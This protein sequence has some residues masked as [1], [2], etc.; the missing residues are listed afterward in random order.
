[1]AV[2]YN[3]VNPTHGRQTETHH[4]HIM[5]YTDIF[6]AEEL[7]TTAHICVISHG[8]DVVSEGENI[9]H[10][11][12]NVEVL[13][14]AGKRISR[15]FNTLSVYSR[16]EENKILDYAWNSTSSLPL[17][18]VLKPFYLK[19]GILNECTMYD[20]VSKLI[21]KALY[22]T[23]H[24]DERLTVY[25]LYRFLEKAVSH[26]IK[27]LSSLSV[28]NLM[29]ADILDEQDKMKQLAIA[30]YPRLVNAIMGIDNARIC[31]RGL[32]PFQGAIEMKEPGQ[33]TSLPCLPNMFYSLI[34]EG[35]KVYHFVEC[36]E[37]GA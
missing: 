30:F 19:H 24:T 17:V 18:D 37:I 35:G 28:Y 22:W 1:M 13:I 29:Y 3:G 4:T 26:E 11:K 9:R 6:K 15:T 20:L 5:K 36:E 7:E 23:S 21:V 10:D 2:A 31:G 16:T 33:C 14:M 34:E 12:I 25:P 27:E 32:K 8:W